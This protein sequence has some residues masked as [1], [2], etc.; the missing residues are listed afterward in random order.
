MPYIPLR[1]IGAGGLVPDQNAYDVE[2]TQFE[3]GNNVAFENGVIGKSLGETDVGITIP[4]KPVAVAGFFDAG[5]NNIFIGARNDIYRYNGSS[6][7][8]VTRS[9]GAYSNSTRWQTEQIGSGMIFNNGSDVPQYISESV[10]SA[11]GN[12][13]DLTN[14]P[15]ALRTESVK[16]YKSF[17]VMT[18]YTESGNT[19]KTRVRWSDE[20]DPS[21]V[22]DDYDTTSATTLAGFT[23]LGGE[24]GDL[25]DQ[26]TLGNTHII[27]AER[28]VY[29]MDFIGAPFVFSFRELFS[30][31]G[32]ISKGACAS[33]EGKHLVVGENDIYVH[34]GSTKKSVADLRVR[35]EFYKSLIDTESVFCKS[36]PS[37]SEVWIF[38]AVQGA[39]QDA[40]DTKYS[41]NKC[42]IYN[43]TN[44][45]FTFRDIT[46]L[47]DANHADTMPQGGTDGTWSSGDLLN[48]DASTE[49]WSN[50]SFGAE[51][52]ELGF[53]AVDHTNSK[54]LL[55]N[56]SRGFAG[57]NINSFVETTKVDLDNVLGTAN[58]N[59]KQINGIMPQMKGEGNV[60]IS[61]GFSNTPTDS[62]TWSQIKTYNLQS[63]H[64]IDVRISGRY[65]ALR[66]ES[67]ENTNYW[68]LSGLDIDVKEVASR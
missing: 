24:N 7:T 63:D 47:R 6:V 23:E 1:K 9:A 45:A 46:N 59:I 17:L 51:A 49:W 25:L 11:N 13:A 5:A 12:F 10:I 64:K 40:T 21:T 56:N 14:W 67:N 15:S 66:F 30:D 18:G 35:N 60:V 65:L 68:T 19:Y 4:T 2:L 41:P 8:T 22:P 55:L 58:N 54:L 34:D 53:F 44:N 42:L 38:Y 50:S 3:N 39:D 20:F 33:W 31:E 37:R 43:W 36:V 29:A 26:L 62:T 32:I 57:S 52:S 61:V 16:P 48:Y 28:G 27:Y